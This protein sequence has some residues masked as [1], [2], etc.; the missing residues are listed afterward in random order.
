MRKLDKEIDIIKVIR[1]L[2]SHNEA[3]K[4]SVM[5]DKKRRTIL[6]HTKQ[7]VVDINTDS[8]PAEFSRYH[9]LYGSENNCNEKHGFCLKEDTLVTENIFQ[10]VLKHGPS[11]QCH[12][13]SRTKKKPTR[14]NTGTQ[15]RFPIHKV[16]D[17]N[18]KVEDEHPELNLSNVENF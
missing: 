5:C 4:S 7:C 12:V 11:C 3:L 2:R 8:D 15:M 18:F 13:V 6:K 1:R 17:Y 10:R 14:M 16:D 9:A